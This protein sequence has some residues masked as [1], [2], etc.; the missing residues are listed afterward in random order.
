MQ[1][2]WI[3][4]I[5]HKKQRY[6]TIG[7]YFDDYGNTLIFVSDMKNEDYEFLVALHEMIEHYLCRKRGIKEKD[8]M[9][10]DVK[11]EAERKKGKHSKDAEPGDDRRAPYRHEHWAATD[12]EKQIAQELK[13][14]WKKY[15]KVVSAL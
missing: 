15:C 2:I 6:D 9:A 1:P 8:I 13:V 12:I 14:D 10:F 11:F 7:D 3:K 4:S 5:P